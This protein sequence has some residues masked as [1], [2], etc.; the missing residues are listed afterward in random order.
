MAV[1]TIDLPADAVAE[2]ERALPKALRGE[3]AAARRY[4]RAWRALVRAL[5]A[6]HGAGAAAAGVLD[7]VAL[8]APFHSGGPLQALMSAAEGIIPGMRAAA[9]PASP[10]PLPAPRE[11]ERFTL[12][13]LGEL[14][15]AASGLD[16]LMAGWDLSISE[17]GRL[18]GVSR[19]AVQQW[20]DE[21]VPAARQPKLLQILRVADLLERNLQP[22]RIPAVVRSEAGEYSGG[23]MLEM[24]AADRH[25]ELVGSV[26]RSFDWAATA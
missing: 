5:I 2:L 6:S 9:P 26:E 24:I 19:Q 7:L 17:V 3:A 16:H 22:Q 1:A 11:Y 14:S 21:G 25:D 23:T 18:F 10:S 13:V 8:T 12:A 4:A 20:L 15:G